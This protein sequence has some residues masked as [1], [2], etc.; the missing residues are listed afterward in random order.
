[1]DATGIIFAALDCDA[2]AIEAWNRWY[3]LEHTPPNLALPGIM[4][5]RRYVAP[6]ELHDVRVAAEAGPFADGRSVFLT[7]YTLCAP[8]SEV[9]DGMV[10]LREKLVAADRMF[11][12]EQKIVRL[13]DVLAR[14][15]VRADPALKADPADVAFIG[16]TAVIAIE[17]TGGAADWYERV[18]APRAL[19]VDGVHAVCEYTSLNRPGIELDLLFVE[20]DPVPLVKELRDAAPHAPEAAISVEAPFL[21]ID[22]LRYPWAESIRRSGLPRTVAG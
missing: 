17:R 15:W 11:P 4:L 8:P 6:P 5:S 13:G 19:G 2:D 12:D 18:W 7:I 22:P 16:H 21:L 10:G 14:S 20:G 3:D 1:M 9:F